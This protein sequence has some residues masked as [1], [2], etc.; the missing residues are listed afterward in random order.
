MKDRQGLFSRVL[1]V[2][3]GR[4]D[5]EERREEDDSLLPKESDPV[6]LRFVKNFTSSGG[7]FLYCGS[8]EEIEETLQ[9][10]SEELGA[11]SSFCPSELCRSQLESLE[12]PFK[13]CSI[14]ESSIFISDCESLVA[15]NGGIMI[16]SRQKG[17]KKLEEIP[18]DVIVLAYADQLVDKLNEGLTAIREKYLRDIPTQ[19]GT[20]HGPHQTVQADSPQSQINNLFLV[21]S[22]R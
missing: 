13:F 11:V 4:P 1:A 7:K 15:Y 12:H 9:H 14:Q 3:S 18:K 22:E 16:T 10:I 20:I 8:Q 17:G 19:I 2:I 21:L 6:D 5:S